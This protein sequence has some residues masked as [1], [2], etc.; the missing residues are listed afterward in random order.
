[1]THSGPVTSL[2]N[3]NPTDTM[4]SQ[5]AADTIAQKVRDRAWRRAND[6]IA[7]HYDGLVKIV[8]STYTRKDERTHAITELENQ[9]MDLI[10]DCVEKVRNLLQG[11]YEADEMD[12]VVKKMDAI[13]DG[14]DDTGSV[15]PESVSIQ[16]IANNGKK[17]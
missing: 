13:L 15:E 4:I 1:M 10:T 7:P 3:H 16:G 6:K 11:A 14:D 8:Q 5:S 9:C 17:N 12:K 2:S